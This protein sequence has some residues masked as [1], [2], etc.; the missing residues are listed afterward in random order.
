MKVLKRIFV[1]LA[2]VIFIAGG[3]LVYQLNNYPSLKLYERYVLTQEPNIAKGQQ[4]TAT[5]L[6]T[7]T[8][9]IRDGETSL[10]TDGFFTRPGGFLKILFGK[11]AP[12]TTIISGVLNRAGVTQLATVMTGHSHYDHAMDAPE[13]AKRTGAL[14]LGSE[15]TANVGRGWGLP[16]DRIK[17]IK[18]GEP[19]SFGQFTVTFIQST[20]GPLNA[21]ISLGGDDQGEEITDPLLPP[22]RAS[23]YKEGGTYSIL[24]EH[25]LG[26]TLIHGSAGFIE[27]ALDDVEADVIFLGIARLGNNKRAYQEAYFR[28]TVQAVGARRIIPIHWDD[29]TVSLEKPLR[30]FPKLLDNFT[31][32]MAFLIEKTIADP[33]LELHL[34]PAWREIVLFDAS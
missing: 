31:G 30:P 28:E 21:P 20:H 17:I 33:Q 1:L 16:E 8:I 13:V 26:N 7:A 24:I 12:D 4:V 6:G 23:A 19:M 5:F 27:G 3:W 18:P 2:L 15:S 9:L 32:A 25:P 29:F 10:M 22:A 14:L 11:V 34:L